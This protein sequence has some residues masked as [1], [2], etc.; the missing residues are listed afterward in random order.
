MR[1]VA[2]VALDGVVGF[3]LGTPLEIF[4]RTR[5]LDGRPGYHVRVGAART[6]V[7]AGLFTLRAPWDLSAIRGAHT[8]V[9]PGVADPTTP[10]PPRVLRALQGVG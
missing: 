1:V 8:V 7:D 6:T 10:V 3:D 2:V 9:V 5:L 4:G